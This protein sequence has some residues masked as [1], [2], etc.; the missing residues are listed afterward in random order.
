MIEADTGYRP[1]ASHTGM[2]S[3][4]CFLWTHRHWL[5]YL[6]LVNVAI[7]AAPICGMWKK[8]PPSSPQWSTLPY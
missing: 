1:F 7:A 4:T 2:V 6:F 5:R 3:C 8:A